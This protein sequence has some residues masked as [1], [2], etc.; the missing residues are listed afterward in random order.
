[1]KSKY[2]KGILYWIAALL[3]PFDEEDTYHDFDRFT[4]GKT[5]HTCKREEEKYLMEKQGTYNEQETER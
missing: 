5:R 1:M 3:Y 2:S 4:G